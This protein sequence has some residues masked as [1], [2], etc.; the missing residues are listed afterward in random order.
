[1]QKLLD[2]GI[3]LMILEKNISELLPLADRM[4]L[5]KGGKIHTEFNRDQ[6]QLLSDKDIQ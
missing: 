1:M 6:L 5:V 4:I 2:R 3:A